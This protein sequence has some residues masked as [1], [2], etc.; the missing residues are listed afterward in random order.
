LVQA[1]ELRARLRAAQDEAGRLR[2]WVRASAQV[3]QKLLSDEEPARVLDMVAQQALQISGA[4]LVLISLPAADCRD[5]LIVEHAVGLGAADALG[6]AFSATRSASGIV[7]ASGAP[8]TVDDFSADPRVSVEGRTRLGLGPAVLIPLGPAGDVRGVL[9]AGRRSGSRPLAPAAAEMATTFAAQAGIGIELAERRR[10]AQRVALFADRDR[11][12]RDL[13]DLVIQRL[14][15]TGMALQGAASLIPGAAAAERVQRAVDDLDETIREIRGTIFR[16]QSRERP[17]AP[18][19]QARIVAVAQEMTDATGLEPW[20]RMDGRLDARVPP[21][22][23]DDL[24]AALREALSNVG[25]HARATQVDVSVEAAADLLLTV[26]DNG[27]GLGEAGPRSGLAN[28]AQRASG[29]GGALGVGPA[30]GGG[31]ELRWQ[32]PLPA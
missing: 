25:R 4:D 9:T 18:A 17:D 27:A 8:M 30:R 6:L 26:R 7:M 20:L 21:E 22:I 13:H 19:L 32:V 12:A 15:A 24:L 10:S 16:L 28:L 14:F 2:Q 3:A 29:R 5:T 23:A 11:I 1:Q 31:T